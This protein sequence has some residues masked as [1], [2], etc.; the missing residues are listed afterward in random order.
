MD[1]LL[2]D[3]RHGVGSVGGARDG[4]ENG[5]AAAACDREGFAGRRSEWTDVRAAM[6][7]A[8]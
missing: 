4:S 1:A 5:D 2:I 8:L 6:A 3:P 7:A